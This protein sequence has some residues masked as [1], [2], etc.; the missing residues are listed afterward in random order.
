[1][2]QFACG[3]LQDR[4]ADVI[5]NSMTLAFRTRTGSLTVRLQHITG[6]WGAYNA[7]CKPTID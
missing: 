4:A 2:S 6:E 5:L 3:L 1:M 7:I